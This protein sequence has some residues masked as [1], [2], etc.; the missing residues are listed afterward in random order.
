MKKIK[1]GKKELGLKASPLALF[2]YRQEFGKDLVADLISL[3]DLKN[4]TEEDFSS[5]DS[6]KLLQL[7]YIMNKASKFG[8]EFPNFEDWLNDLGY[9]DFS[10]ESWMTVVMEE[11]KSGFFRQAKDEGTK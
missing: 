10:D 6:V 7:I 5:F 11:A 2:Y 1:I 8:K 4:I 9:I 3:Q